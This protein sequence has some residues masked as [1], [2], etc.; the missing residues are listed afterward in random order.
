MKT[1][2]CTRIRSGHHHSNFIGEEGGI[3]LL[4]IL[5]LLAVSGST[6]R[7]QAE[8][9]IS[10][11]GSDLFST[12]TY[13][14]GDVNVGIPETRTFTIRNSGT[15][16][17]M[18]STFQKT[19]TH[20]ANYSYTG[21]A[22]A[23]I[24]AGN[25]TPFTITFTPSAAGTRNATISITN[26]D[27]DENPFVI[28]LTGTG[29]AVP[30]IA[31]SQSGV[32]MTDGLTTVNFGNVN[33]GLTSRRTFSIRN[34]GLAGLTGLRVSLS[35]SSAWAVTSL[36]VSSL[37]SGSSTSFTV[38]FTPVATA[39][40]GASLA[41]FSNDADEN[42]FNISLAGT[43][44]VPLIS[45]EQ[46]DG[47]PLFDGGDVITMTSPAG[48]SAQRSFT[49]RNVSGGILSGFAVS[50]DGPGAPDF[51]AG[52]LAAASLA[53]DE[54]MVFLVTFTPQA[55]GDSMAVLH[56]DCDQTPGDPF[57]IGLTG[58]NVELGDLG[59]EDGDGAANLLERATG[60]DPLV[61]GPHPG[62]LVKN[63]SDLVMTF[64]RR[65]SM[66]GE[67]EL[68]V[69]WSDT[70]SGVWTTVDISAAFL[71]ED[72]GTLQQLRYT[73]PAGYSGYRF[74]RLRVTRLMP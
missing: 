8:I 38:S 19:G 49:I 58:S 34:A 23:T 20:A 3:L 35:G 70:L 10:Q 18:V 25:S 31:V 43:G 63:G 16:A 4:L 42:P 29:V 5:L 44:I 52:A 2:V 68:T 37:A 9:N 7:A 54:A 17:L 1:P 50:I 12:G 14:F 33:I 27:G 26:T 61:S 22:N 32:N 15:A 45:V 57:D 53:P 60:S 72:D 47:T 74:V 40:S 30:E 66:I 46:P 24:L 69:E 28:N 6:V 59:D 13:N 73:F 55:P 71:L 11:G 65:K 48:G 39:P 56:I 36:S 67:A 64:Y 41:I 21:A 62:D 51:V